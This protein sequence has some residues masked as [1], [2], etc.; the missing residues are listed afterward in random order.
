MDRKMNWYCNYTN[1]GDDNRQI[2][3]YMRLDY[4]FQLLETQKYHVTRRREFED[5][6]EHFANKSRLFRFLPVGENTHTN[7]T[8]LTNQESTKSI[9]NLIPESD[10]IHCP[11]S[12]WTLQKEENYLMWK[13]YATEFGIRIKSTI[14]NFIASL[15]LDLGEDLKNKVV[16]GEMSYFSKIYPYTEDDSQLFYKNKVYSGE[17]EFRFYF[18]LSDE[19][20]PNRTKTSHLLIPIDTKVL[21]DEILLSPFI[22]K[23]AANKFVDVIITS[24]GID[25]VRQSNIKIR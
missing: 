6:D 4:L 22:G 2:C 12:C 14:K 8:I 13:T 18:Y 11:T 19:D 17:E 9:D 5:I 7:K 25:N 21:I 24:Y 3:Q 23:E 20:D 16:C 10:I 15:K 1:E